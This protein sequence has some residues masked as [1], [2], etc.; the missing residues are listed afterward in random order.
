MLESCGENWRS[1]ATFDIVKE[2]VLLIWSNFIDTLKAKTKNS[3]HSVS[4]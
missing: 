1:E 4:L 2:G 3:L